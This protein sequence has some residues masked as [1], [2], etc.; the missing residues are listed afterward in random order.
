MDAADFDF[1]LLDL[2]HGCQNIFEEISIDFLEAS[3]TL[4]Q[5]YYEPKSKNVATSIVSP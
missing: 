2:N 5:D 4:N 3:E 1:D